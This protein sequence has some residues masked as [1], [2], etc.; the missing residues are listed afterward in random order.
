MHARLAQY[1]TV[2]EIELLHVGHDVVER[3]IPDRDDRTARRTFDD[4]RAARHAYHVRLAELLETGWRRTGL[5]TAAPENALEAAIDANPDD[6]AL[7]AVHAD[8]LLERN[9]ARGE[10][11]SLHLLL[12][13]HDSDPIRLREQIA[14][15]EK[16]HADVLFGVV[17]ALGPHW[18]GQFA[19][20]WKHGW[21]D[22]V[23]FEHRFEIDNRIF[24][25]ERIRALLLEVLHMPVARFVQG[26]RLD[27]VFADAVG[28]AR[29]PGK[30]R[31]LRLS[32][33]AGCTDAFEELIVQLPR[34]EQLEM[35]GNPPAAGHVGVRALSLIDPRRLAGQWTALE[36]LTLSFHRG[37][38]RSVESL[39]TDIAGSTAAPRLT[40]LYI[41]AEQAGQPLR[42]DP[43]IAP[44]LRWPGIARLRRLELR[45]RVVM[46]ETRA[47]LEEL[48]QRH[49]GLD[50]RLLQ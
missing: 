43:I 27:R 1:G 12:E 42:I 40:E 31:L 47:R 15:V 29:W 10:L 39:F 41:A 2:P 18:R 8:W 11:A 4:E 36:R 45:G 14:A 46:R 50:L 49:S 6:A 48:R 38:N 24:G 5:A 34:L 22:E 20:T 13:R 21:V 30:D 19:L 3:L 16:Q 28:I 33:P 44:L 37:P 9:D 23:T 17:A 25:A 7:R 26:L 32:L 35:L